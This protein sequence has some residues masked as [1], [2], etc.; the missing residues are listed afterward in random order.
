M[1]AAADRWATQ[2]GPARVLAAARSLLEQR[3]SG[4]QVRVKVTLTEAERGQVGRLL[5]LAWE[6]S[7]AAITLGK[8]RAAIARTGDDLD[9]LLTRIGGPLDDL[10]ARRARDAAALTAS[11]DGAHDRLIAAGIPA[12]A[13]ALARRRRW[14]G[15][16]G[17][18]DLAGRADALARLWH[19]LPMPGRPLPE[20]SNTLFADTHRLDR[21]AELGRVAARLLAAAQ[22]DPAAAEQAADQALTAA[23]WRQVWAAYGISCDE[24]S[25]TVLILGLTLTGGSAAAAIS[26]AAASCGEP[27]WLTERSLRGDWRPGAGT[28]VVRVCENPAIVETG[29]AEFGAGCR[30]LVCIY[31]Q[32][33]SAAWTLLRGL[34]TAG[35]TLLVTADRDKSGL[36]FLADML[37]LPGA[38]EW[39]PDAD[40]VYEEARLPDLLADLRGDGIRAPGVA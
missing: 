23:R 14:L 29:A 12:H 15:R 35:V 31:G 30:P 5:G 20:L 1:S 8:L 16:P 28:S 25:S 26:Q 18:A 13:V 2:T 4:D 36:R 10:P 17:A 19:L 3:R 33:S 37:A 21:E 7:G 6:T 40:G 38:Q 32:P 11:V 34:A 27:V 9:A 39:L 22:A 24:V